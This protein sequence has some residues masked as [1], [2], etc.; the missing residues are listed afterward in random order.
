MNA[1][2]IILTINNL[3]LLLVFWAV[4]KGAE[5]VKRGKRFGIYL[6]SE[7][8]NDERVM[9]ICEKYQN[10][11]SHW[12]SVGLLSSLL[13]L[14]PTDYFSITFSLFMIWTGLIIYLKLKMGAQAMQ[15]LKTLKAQQGWENPEV[16]ADEKNWL[17][18]GVIYYNPSSEKLFKASPDF[19]ASYTFN[20]ATRAGKISWFLIAALLLVT[21]LP[22]WGMIIV[23]DLL[24]PRVVI[25][26]ID[27]SIKSG[28][29]SVNVPIDHI[30]SVQW[31]EDLSVGSKQSGSSTA[32]YKR[33]TF[34]IR[35]K[36]KA[37]VY[38][39]N[40]VAEKI[41]VT[42]SED[43]P[44]LINMKTSEETQQLFQ[45]LKKASP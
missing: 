24:P 5:K 15:A 42:L 27:L 21:L 8:L 25:S 39:F 33:G 23:D 34:T 31:A 36:G 40:H 22:A 45:E 32:L 2:G 37:R 10:Q 9:A 43:K 3:F 17:W 29:S 14:F 11:N 44:I 12:L 35:N 18:G 28:F 16:D 38:I 1:I 26:D 19:P 41:W 20:L 30:E 4:T 13:P 7:R 6:P